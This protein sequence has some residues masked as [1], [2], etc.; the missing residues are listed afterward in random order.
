MPNVVA[1]TLALLLVAA[2][3][4]A[5]AAQGA[6]PQPASQPTPAPATTPSR[7]QQL[8]G[9]V[10]PKL[11]ELTDQVLFGDVWERPGL[12]KR[13]RSLITVATLVALN[14]PDQLRSHMALALRNGVTPTELTELVTHMS[15]YAGWPAGAS[16]IPILRDTLKAP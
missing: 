5:V 8:M 16:A 9:D 6:P 12:S 3:P 11:A 4:F 2:S 15:F 1:R 10:N 13:D 7:A 14:R